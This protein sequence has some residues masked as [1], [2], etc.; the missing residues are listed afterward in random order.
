MYWHNGTPRITGISLADAICEWL[1][2]SNRQY[3]AMVT[4]NDTTDACWGVLA[5]TTHTLPSPEKEKE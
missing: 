3:H 1:G 2:I 5:N 4:M